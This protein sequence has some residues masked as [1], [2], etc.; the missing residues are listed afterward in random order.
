MQHFPLPFRGGGNAPV[1]FFQAAGLPPSP[2]LSFPKSR[3]LFI[4][5]GGERDRGGERCAEPPERGEEEKR[6]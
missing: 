2:L 6:P 3:C 5:A 1:L 4:E